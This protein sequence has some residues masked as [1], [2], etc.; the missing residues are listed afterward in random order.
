MKLGFNPTLEVE[1]TINCKTGGTQP[2]VE[3]IFYILDRSA[4]DILKENKDRTKAIEAEKPGDHILYHR[5]TG[6]GRNKRIRGWSLLRL[7]HQPN[8]LLEYSGRPKA[9]QKQFEVKMTAYS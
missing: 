4:S 2:I 7:R 8:R 5:L 3:Q 1:A 9:G 6:E